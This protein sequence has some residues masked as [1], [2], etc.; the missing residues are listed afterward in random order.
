MIVAAFLFFMI[1]LCS[2]GRIPIEE[3]KLEYISQLLDESL[4]IEAWWRQWKTTWEEW[5]DGRNDS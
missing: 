1:F 3:Q 2:T 5:K 4:P